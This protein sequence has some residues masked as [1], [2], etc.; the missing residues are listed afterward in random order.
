MMVRLTPLRQLCAAL[1]LCTFFFSS[2]LP[3]LW[4]GERGYDILVDRPPPAGPAPVPKVVV[5]FGEECAPFTAGV[6][7]D[8]TIV[9]KIGA[10]E[11]PTKL[12][13]YLNRL[14]RCKQDLLIF[15]DRRDSY[16]GFE[17]SDALAHLRPEYKFDNP[18][19]EVYDL[20]QTA[21]L[22]TDKTP[23][24]W[25][26]DKYKFLPM[27][28]WTSYLRPRSQWYLFLELDTYVNYDNMYRFLSNFNSHTAYYFGSPVWPKKKAI[29]AH[30]G[31]GFVLSRAAL[32]KIMAL[33]RMFG[34]N[35]HFPGTH[36]FGVDVRSQC[37]GDEVLAQ[38]LKKSGVPLRGY[39]PMFNGEKPV[40]IRFD[41]E[42]W[43]EAIMTMHHLNEED[44]TSLSQWEKARSHPE[45]PLM[46]EEL[47]TFIEPHLR[48]KA[49]DWSNLSEDVTYKKS[50]S[51]SKSF[52]SCQKACTKDSSCMQFQHTGSECR[53]G[54]SIR[55]G[56][57]HP[58]EGDRQ[59]TSGWMLDRIKAFK[60]ARSPCQGARFVHSNP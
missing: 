49:E 50:K 13:A 51:A 29:F 15:S 42:Q 21:N 46:F 40:T 41:N 52:D 27:M 17:I 8:V 6:M 2:L 57:H 5:P 26:L 55:L 35:K 60:Q 31:S 34:E 11:V 32:D 54:Y 20:I 10:G 14:G 43:C 1:L 38:V 7:D 3:R 36:F 16:N 28:E 25:R 59:W 47:F 23:D 24:G 37:C 53:L 48:Q 33:G 22:T 39:W 18:D 44:F 30:G 45:Q 58:R 9:L 4:R 12:P 56:Y 19:F